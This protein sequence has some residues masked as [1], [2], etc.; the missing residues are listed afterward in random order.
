MTGSAQESGG[1]KDGDIYV[2][3]ATNSCSQIPDFSRVL[4]SH[5]LLKDHRTLPFPKYNK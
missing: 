2:Q 3:V 1:S 4:N 5:G